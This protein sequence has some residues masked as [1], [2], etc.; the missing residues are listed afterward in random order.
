MCSGVRFAVSCARTAGRAFSCCLANPDSPAPSFR[1]YF[2]EVCCVPGVMLEWEDENKGLPPF[3]REALR[4]KFILLTA[5]TFVCVP[6][7]PCL[8]FSSLRGRDHPSLPNAPLPA[9]WVGFPSAT[10]DVWQHHF[11]ALLACFRM[12]SLSVG[13]SSC[14]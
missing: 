13:L 5:L 2:S 4:F 1:R 9:L 14:L 7:G 8:P 11:S 12:L 10:S 3:S 6:S